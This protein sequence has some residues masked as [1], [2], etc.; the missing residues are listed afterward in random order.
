MIELVGLR[1]DIGGSTVVH[2]VSLSVAPGERVG[3]VG[4]SGSGKT[5]TV[6]AAVGLLPDGAATTG[7]IAVDRDDLSAADDRTWS[8]VRGSRIGM[9]FQEPSLALN[10]LLCIG[11]QI[12]IPLRRHGGFSR[13]DARSR[14]S[15]ACAA[16]SL[17]PDVLERRP[18]EVSGGQRQRAC[19][20]IA[21]ARD[22]AILVADEPT[23][24][25]D[26]T[27]QHE[28]LRL[29]DDLVESRGLGVL[30]VSHDLAVVA[31]RTD[32]VVVLDHGRVA[33]TSASRLFRAGGAASE[34]GRR[35]VAAAAESDRRIGSLIDGERP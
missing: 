3:L 24:A 1:V 29:L 8:R 23:T 18:H 17:D 4:G 9:V 20:A 22:P 33:E 2:D 10:P 27:V 26:P 16:V 35:L 25:L 19:I 12:A 5:M 6:L 7:R 11:E 31:S 15:A 28:V 34:A 21:L 30:L 32:R 14:A 13:R